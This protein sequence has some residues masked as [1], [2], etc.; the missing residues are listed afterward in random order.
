MQI[1]LGDIMFTNKQQER[2]NECF[3][4]A[5]HFH[6]LD[7]VVVRDERKFRDYVLKGVG[8]IEDIWYEDTIQ[9]WRYYE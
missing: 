1:Y 6:T 4:Y 7:T 8:K 9:T 3:R 2:F 5:I